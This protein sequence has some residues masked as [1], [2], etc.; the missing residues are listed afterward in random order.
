MNI[1][2]QAHRRLLDAVLTFVGAD[3]DGSKAEIR[4]AAIELRAAREN[5]QAILYPEVK[6]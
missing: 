6:P 5:S 4:A 2:E 3:E 1:Q